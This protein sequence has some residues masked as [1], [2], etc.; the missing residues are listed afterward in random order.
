MRS[1]RSRHE[2]EWS[3]RSYS[4][5]DSWERWESEGCSCL[6]VEDE[7]RPQDLHPTAANSSMVG[8]YIFHL[9]FHSK[10]NQSVIAAKP[11]QIRLVDTLPYLPP[12]QM[13]PSSKT[14]PLKLVLAQTISSLRATRSTSPSPP[15]IPPHPYASAAPSHIRRHRD[16]ESVPPRCWRL[17]PVPSSLP[18]KLQR[19]R[20]TPGRRQFQDH[21]SVSI[22]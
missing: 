20:S 4:R 22:L 15:S 5:W 9:R 8:I 18:A 11:D 16:R 12:N 19:R 14:K 21:G 1:G 10:P 2:S 7:G 3:R 17:E 13:S 6:E